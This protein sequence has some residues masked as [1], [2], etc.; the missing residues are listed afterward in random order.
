MNFQRL[1]V[2]SADNI[3][4]GTKPELIKKLEETWNI[5]LPKEFRGFMMEIGYAEIYGDEIYSIYDIP[6]KIPCKGLHWMNKNNKELSKG[7]FEFFSNDIDGRFYLNNKTGKIY[8]NSTENEFA[9]SFSKFID[10]L[11]NE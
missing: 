11:L 5:T 4:S 2:H 6:D 10:K 1:K 3:G 8:Q 9:D 7:Y